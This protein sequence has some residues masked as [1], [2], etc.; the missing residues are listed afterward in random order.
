MTR[1]AWRSL[2]THLGKFL[3]TT[4]AVVLEVTFLSGT[5]A[6]R[7]VLSDT[8]SALTAS[9]LT[10]DLYVSG[11]PITQ[12]AANGGWAREPVE[13]AASE[14]LEQVPG[15]QSV[16]A[17]SPL[18]LVLVG[19]DQAPVGTLGAPSMG[20]PI[21]DDERGLEIVKGVRPRSQGQIS[22]DSDT[23]RRS[24]L[25][26][27]DRTHIV[28]L[29]T[30]MEVEVVGEFSYGTSLAGAVIVGLDPQWMLPLIAPDGRVQ[31]LELYLS[32]GT[33]ATQVKQAVSAAMP[34]GTQVRTRA[35]ELKEQ[36][37]QIEE[38]LGYVQTFLLVFVVLAMFVGSFIIMNTF[39][40]SVR[41]RQK[42]FALLR[43][44]GASTF[45]VFLTVL[46]QALVVG[47]VGSALGVLAGAGM[48]RLLVAL[49][50]AGGMELPGGVPMTSQIAI[51]SVVVG[52]LVTVVGALLPA[53]D[54]ALTAP[55][56]AMRQVS[57]AKDKPLVLRTVI[58]LLL[59][60]AGLAGVLAAWHATGLANRGAVL[61][62]GAGALLLGVLVVSP[63]LSRPVVTALGLPLRVLR[64][65]GRLGAR[66]LV[67]APRRTA[68]TSA[69]LVIGVALVSA[70]ATV[71]AS[72]KESVRDVVNDS[73]H[74]ELLVRA[75]TLNQL[76]ALPKEYKDR[77]SQID[78]VAETSGF[79][80]S[81]VS[82][83]GPGQEPGTSLVAAVDAPSYLRAWDP[84][85]VS[86]S[87]ECLD[88]SHV[89]AFKTTGFKEGDSVTVKGPTGSVQA[90]VCGVSDAK[91]VG[92]SLY[93]NAGLA[94]QAGDLL[95]TPT[96]S[97]Q[98]LLDNP[99]GL[100]LTLEPGADLDKV[101]EQI[102]DVVA[103]SYVFQV[104]D[105]DQISDQAGQ[106][107]NQM[108][109]VLYALLGLSIAIAVLGI[110]NTLVLSVS[111]RTREIGLMRAVG[112]G[113]SQLAGVIVTE[114]VLTAVYGTVLGAGTGLLLAAAL[115]S[116][117]ADQGLTALVVPWGQLVGM[118]VTAVVV[119]VLASLWPA[120]RATRLPVLEAIASE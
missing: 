57:G 94:A 60:T 84:V 2:R 49:L 92:A 86:G 114:S 27:G 7:S 64:P 113:R 13:M 87:L 102:K 48:T 41:Q 75:F 54:A 11:A 45:S 20:V 67:A 58:G 21:Y 71:T 117:L 19:K 39:A 112:L 120:L 31:S 38:I 62:A 29:G 68:A 51:T 30:P 18:Q 17:F 118:V 15:V 101:R 16:H 79:H 32:E 46:L 55:V 90:T 69:A 9:T 12:N 85:M 53:R 44:V 74:A 100:L 111:E 42:E 110:V 26:V 34:A 28:V 109:A 116:Y 36:N 107:A 61:G 70:G 88:D 115:R 25:T 108:L 40:M 8:F 66:N 24:G 22:L 43:A 63:V 104:L 10:A 105:Q 103:P 95:G 96:A 72:M 76:Q 89:V 91:G 23:A 1:V 80:V 3:L 50:A 98:E 4:L 78:G 6:L 37:S 83:A 97:A 56:E 35:E 65:G 119:G 33:D 93:M 106:Q 59:T 14:Q 81:M 47:L 73:M 52:M 77:I 5:L 82:V 99:H